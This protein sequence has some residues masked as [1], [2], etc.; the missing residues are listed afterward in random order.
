M[1]TIVLYLAAAGCLFLLLLNRVLIG[2]K[3]GPAKP[4]AIVFSF[5]ALT[6]TAVGLGAAAPSAWAIAPLIILAAT[7]LGE[8]RRAWIRWR[9]RGEPPAA[10]ASA[11]ISLRRPITTTDLAVAR[12][13]LRLPHWRG[14]ALRIAHI[15]DLHLNSR[16]P[17]TYYRSVI[18]QVTQAQPD[19]VFFTG[20]FVTRVEF[21]PG[22]TPLLAG[23]RS[24]WGVF[25]VLGNHDFWAGETATAAAVQAAGVTLLA[26]RGQVVH[27]GDGAEVLLC[28]YEAP[29]G[30]D[31]WHRPEVRPG[32]LAIALTHTPDNIYRLS[33]LGFS[34]VFAG[35]YHAGQVRLPGLGALVV[36]SAYGRRFDHGHFVVNGAHLFVTAGVGAAFPP[37]R[38]YCQPDLFIVD[39]SSA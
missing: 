19:L 26:D 38:L 21:A 22:L 39:V 18:A 29:D 2:M 25:A 33:Q 31:G 35:H 15:S 10:R 23:V 20:D 37:F 5:L 32:Q 14:P 28:G 8:A 1:V 7:G 13:E 17:A 6:G 24:R 27:A 4:V 9:C 36:P 12:Y 34:A 16:L 3:D 11:A 30:A